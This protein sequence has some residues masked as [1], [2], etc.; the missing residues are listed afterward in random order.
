MSSSSSD[1][2]PADVF[3]QIDGSSIPAPIYEN[4]LQVSVEESLHLPGMFTLVIDN[5]YF[6]GRTQD[7]PWSSGLEELFRIGNE[8]EIGFASS[9]AAAEFAKEKEA[10]SLFKGEITAVETQF[11]SESQAPF[12]VRGYDVSHRLHRGCQNRSFLNVTDTDVIKHLAQEKGISLGE[13]EDSGQPHDYLFQQNQTNMEFMRERAARIGFELFVKDGKLNFRKPKQEQLLTL[14]WLH[15]FRSFRVRVSSSEQVSS[16]EVRS[17]DYENK[18]VI[19]VTR[20]SENVL[21]QNDHGKGTQIAGV[22]RGCPPPKLTVVDQ[23][24]FSVGEAE[25]IAQSMID[26]LGGEYVQADAGGQGN[27]EIRAGRA[28]NLQNISS[29]TGGPQATMGKYDGQYYVTECR[30]LYHKR[31]Y[32]TEFT[33]RGLRGGNLLSMVAPKKRL[34]PGQTILVGVVTDNQDPKSMGRVKVKFPTL[35]EQHSSFWVRMSA[36]GAGDKRGFDVLPEINDEVVCAFEH[37]DIRRAYLIGGVWNGKDKT[38]EPSDKDIKGNKVNLR[39]FKTRVGH[40]LQFVEED[41]G[42]KKKG[43][44]IKTEGGHKVKIS[45]GEKKIELETA[46]K[47]LIKM[48]DKPNDDK[49]EIKTQGGHKI[50]LEDLAGLTPEGLA[51][52]AISAIGGSVGVP[53]KRGISIETST[54][55]KIKLDEVA[56][57][58]KIETPGDLKISMDD[59]KK[60]IKIESSGCIELKADK[61]IDLKAKKINFNSKP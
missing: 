37:G 29:G 45:D 53:V 57:E 25:Q 42:D 5:S 52:S 18:E 22:F 60:T 26:E 41:D 49:I 51:G 61:D 2:K 44:F 20:S 48:S 43:V 50:K 14:K 39:T 21:T 59:Q 24:V 30:H 27:P 19:S 6:P 17:W 10:P 40:T 1:Y 7:D 13:M 55:Y 3:I 35:T 33:V 4:I 34:A 11:T 56:R 31:T 12:V 54:K 38:P 58:L 8:I 36:A 46:Q 9:T 23:P 47:H 15:D 28:I 32:T 16:V